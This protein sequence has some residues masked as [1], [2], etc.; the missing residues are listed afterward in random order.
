MNIIRKTITNIFGNRNITLIYILLF[1]FL[2]NLSTLY[3]APPIKFTYQG[4]IRQQGILI[5]GQRAMKFYIYDS[6]YS[7]SALWTSP[8]YSVSIST[9][10]FRVILEPDS[11]TSAQWESPELW[12]EL[13]IEGEKLS[14]RER[15]TSSIYSINSAMLSGKK[16]TTSASTPTF[17]SEGDLW[18][19]SSNN[20]INFY[21]GTAW[22]PTSGSGMPGA[23]HTTHEAGGSD[24]I[25]SLGTHTV[26]GSLL[27]AY[28]GKINAVNTQEIS[29]TTNVSINGGLNLSGI[30][31]QTSNL[32]IG[33]PGFGIYASSSI[34][35]GYYYGNGAGLTNINGNNIINQTV[36]K[37]KLSGSGCSV[38]QILAFDGTQW[39][40]A[41]PSAGTETDPWSIHNQD[42]LQAGARFNVS[43]ATVS[44]LYSSNINVYNNL[45]VDK[46]A[47]IGGNGGSNGLNVDNQ[48]NVAIGTPSISPNT[49]MEVV[50][51]SNSGDFVVIYKSGASIGAWLRKK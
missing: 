25:T 19:D 49:K 12:L 4:N 50:G 15:I 21:N 3:A 41:S 37:E 42:V 7:V 14:P 20:V 39:Q 36:T 44:E 2:I 33:G 38:Q 29:I 26:Y 6:S 51:G 31:N 23:H 24:A 9:G 34:T 5:S 40:C 1:Y 10:V 13:E 17:P 35:A 48:G 8:S 47:S 28:P 11:L 27:L 46:T 18:Y 16:Y 32:N 43:S 30:L 22:V 45:R